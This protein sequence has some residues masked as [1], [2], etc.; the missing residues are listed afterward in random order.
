MS[1]PAVA[2]LGVDEVG[3]TA[4]PVSVPPRTASVADRQSTPGVDSFHEAPAPPAQPG[5]LLAPSVHRCVTRVARTP[6]S[7][8]VVPV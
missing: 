3:A 7:L 5:L 8:F 2:R 1:V 4:G 6:V